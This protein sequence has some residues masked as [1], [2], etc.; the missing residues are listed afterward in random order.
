LAAKSKSS[1]RIRS[2]GLQENVAVNHEENI[3]VVP[4]V[5]ELKRVLLSFLEN[6]LLYSKEDVRKTKEVVSFFSNLI[7]D[8][9]GIQ[10]SF[11]TRNQYL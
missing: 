4:L 5:S 1:V 9:L 8:S 3:A 10:S 11:E 7:M 2:S 6:R